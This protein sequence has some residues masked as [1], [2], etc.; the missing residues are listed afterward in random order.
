MERKTQCGSS[1]LRHI[2][3]Q[4]NW[5]FASLWLTFSLFRP[6]ALPG[7]TYIPISP[8]PGILGRLEPGSSGG[9]TKWAQEQ[10]KRDKIARKIAARNAFASLIHNIR[11]RSFFGCGNCRIND[12]LP[13][14]LGNGFLG[15][16]FRDY[17][18]IVHNIENIRPHPCLRLGV[19]QD[20]DRNPANSV[21]W[22]LVDFF[23]CFHCSM[24]ALSISI[25]CGVS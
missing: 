23:L 14:C 18:H 17:S 6:G 16:D 21:F 3:R 25:T 12:K 7:P 1:L 9:S 22:I 24:L 2:G 8:D 5:L 13:P 15:T 11:C 4:S 19:A 10:S 20:S